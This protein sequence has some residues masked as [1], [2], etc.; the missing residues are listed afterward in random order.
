MNNTWHTETRVHHSG[1]AS[2]AVSEE[3]EHGSK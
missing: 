3:D 2:G 1:A